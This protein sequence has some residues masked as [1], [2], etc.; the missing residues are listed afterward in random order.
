MVK[1]AVLGWKAL[2]L[3][4]FFTLMLN[5]CSEKKAD[6]PEG[7]RLG[8][9]LALTGWAAPMGNNMLEGAKLAV[10]QVNSAGGIHGRPLELEVEDWKSSNADAT[11]AAKSLIEIKGVKMILGQWSGDV[12]SYLSVSDS[13]NATI[14]CIGCGAPGIT[15]RSAGLFRVWPSDELEV[16]AVIENMRLKGYKKPAVIYT[17]D[18]WSEGLYKS[19]IADWGDVQ[20]FGTEPGRTDFRTELLK[21]K[22]S[23]ADA[24]Y[25]P[26]FIPDAGIAIRQA[27]EL[28]LDAALYSTSSTS[29][30][31][32]LSAAGRSA[33]GVVFPRYTPSTDKFK[34][35]YSSKFGRQPGLY[36]DAGYDAV[37]ILAD[38]LNKNDGDLSMVREGLY[39][40]TDYPGAS[41]TIT[42]DKT[43]NRVSRDI[44]MLTIKDGAP[45]TLSD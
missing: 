37:M 6:A 21:V 23:G 31:S 33:D 22:E 18:P 27:R 20:S 25:L 10:D 44:Q 24:I 13:A 30:P 7:I 17:I 39:K 8:A 28:D 41:G 34:Q 14:I 16:N 36:A 35:D 9:V 4:V 43:R 19:F 45:V 2:V 11:T 29:D 40:I 5:G 12:L 38:V 42:I 32:V 1:T 26:L 3:L 15:E